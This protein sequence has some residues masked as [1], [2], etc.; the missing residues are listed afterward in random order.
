[1]LFQSSYHWHPIGSMICNKESS[2]TCLYLP[3]EK[4]IVGRDSYSTTY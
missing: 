1:M 4:H 2:L 3:Q